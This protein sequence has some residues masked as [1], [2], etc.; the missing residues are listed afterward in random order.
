MEEIDYGIIPP[1]ALEKF[2]ENLKA[3]LNNAGKAAAIVFCKRYLSS[4]ASCEI[5]VQSM[6]KPVIFDK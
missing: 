5:I 1:E 3:V 4:E 6:I 2:K